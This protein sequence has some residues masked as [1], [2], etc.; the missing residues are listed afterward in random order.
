MSITVF[1]LGGSL[2]DLPDLAVRLQKAFSKL[3]NGRPLVI[4][5]G[6]DAADIVRRWHRTFG[7]D[8][9]RSHWLALDAIRLNQQLLLELIPKLEL[10]PTRQ[11]AQVALSHD[12]IPLLDLAEFLRTEEALVEPT[13]RLPHCWDVTSDSLAAWVAARWP[14]DRLILLKSVDLPDA[15]TDDSEQL[16]SAGLIDSFFPQL[17]N[18]IP[19]IEWINLRQEGD[20][21]WQQLNR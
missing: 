20:I 21:N 11:A 8:E 14:A 10:V 18:S 12:R 1:K 9:E 6:G 7:L 5:G 13:E 15:Q 2:L 16:A 17:T 4:S 3:G 19:T